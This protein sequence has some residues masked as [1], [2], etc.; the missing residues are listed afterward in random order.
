LLD[1]RQLRSDF[2]R[3]AWQSALAKISWE[4]FVEQYEHHYEALIF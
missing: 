1:D 3:R 2:A 4:R